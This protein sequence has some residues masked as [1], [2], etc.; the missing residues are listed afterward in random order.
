MNRRLTL[1]K[2]MFWVLFAGLLP[3][4]AMGQRT[5]ESVKVKV[6]RSE[7]GMVT[8]ME[9]NVP[10]AEG[11]D[12]ENL[13][14][15]Y[16][17]EDELGELKPG[18][19][20]EITIRRKS[21]AGDTDVNITMDRD[22][23]RTE[24]PV[25]NMVSRAF[26]GVHYEMTYG[27][28]IGSRINTVV[29][30]TPAEK[31]ALRKD[32][33]ITAVD[34]ERL[35]VLE[36]LARI[37]SRHKPGD[38]VMLSILR[39]GKKREYPV[40]LGERKEHFFAPGN[41]DTGFHYELNFDEMMPGMKVDAGAGRAF[42]GVTFMRNDVEINGKKINPST[43]DLIISGVIDNSA[44]AEMGLRKGDHLTRL[45]GKSLDS[46][47]ELT[48]LV[49]RMKP[50]D[51]VIIDFER[52]GTPMVVSGTLKAGSPGIHQRRIEKHF[53]GLKHGNGGRPRRIDPRP[54]SE[55]DRPHG[56]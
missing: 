51:R 31:A 7:D 56:K 21:P 11:E 19:E 27:E 16:G 10:A 41:N 48:D 13:L 42:L 8:Q 35:F 55:P 54:R 33:I 3:V 4:F 52:D 23:E 26:L 44:A 39:D 50:G 53:F 34:G 45:N 9:E 36:D 37:V 30:G 40:T 6:R 28:A 15:K 14:K 38:R 1:R 17:V 32:D 29:S 2:A 5:D 25:E 18:E 24:V 20:V 22:K 47:S 43:N 46:Y 12:L 49:G